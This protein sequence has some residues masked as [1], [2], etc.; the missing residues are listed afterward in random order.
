MNKKYIDIFLS[1]C[2]V[3]LGVLLYKSTLELK[4]SSIV[5]TGFYIKFLAIS[6]ALSAIVEFIKAIL[7]KQKENVI[8]AKD[9]KRF[10]LLI[11]FLI[12]Y[13]WGMEYLGFIIS[14]A[15]FLPITMWFMGYKKLFRASIIS[16]IV[17]IFVHL[18]FAQ[19]FE[20]PLPKSTVFGELE[21]L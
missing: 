16:V 2:F 19:V 18:L 12:F 1:I 6:L 9:I 14:S 11:L 20:I 21:W 10:I 15:I 7:E 13:V 8:F 5:T 4:T 3:V 17:I